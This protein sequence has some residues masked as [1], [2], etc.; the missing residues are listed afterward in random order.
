M[1]IRIRN[2]PLNFM[3]IRIHNTVQN[4]NNSKVQPAPNCYGGFSINTVKNMISNPKGFSLPLSVSW[5]TYPRPQEEGAEGRRD[6]PSPFSYGR[7]AADEYHRF[8]TGWNKKKLM[9][10]E[11]N[12]FQKGNTVGNKWIS[13]YLTGG[14]YSVANPERLRQDPDT[15]V[16]FRSFRI[17]ILLPFK[18]GQPNNWPI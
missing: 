7:P 3:R 8:L 15:T 12:F 14:A 2:L 13:F 10:I 11:Q 5:L 1:R 16:L 9:F 17:R 6:L 18:P 4:S